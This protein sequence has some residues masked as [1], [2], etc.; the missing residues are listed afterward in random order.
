MTRIITK[1]KQVHLLIFSA[2][3]VAPGGSSAG[4]GYAGT[5]GY[6]LES[7]GTTIDNMNKKRIQ[8]PS[9][10]ISKEGRYLAYYD[11]LTDQIRFRHKSQLLTTSVYNEPT[12]TPV[13]HYSLIAGGRTGNTAG[14]FVSIA[15]KSGDTEAD[16]VVVAVWYTGSSLMYA[17]KTNPAN[18]NDA[19]QTGSR[20]GYWSKPKKVFENLSSVGE[21]CQIA[22]DKNGGIHIAASD[23][24]NTALV[25]AYMSDYK[26]V[27]LKTCTIDSYGIIGTHITLDVALSEKGKPIPYIGY[28]SNS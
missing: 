26:G 21:Y 25:Y 13:D 18:D 11:M 10:A 1:N 17:Y 4:E 2:K 23:V 24:G 7:L 9:L 19:D 14:E 28:F 8:S 16:D 3:D 22:V 12:V 20:V 5:G 6:R 15:V 27:D